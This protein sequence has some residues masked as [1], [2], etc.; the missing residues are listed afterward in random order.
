MKNETQNSQWTVLAGLRFLLATLVVMTHSEVVAPGSIVDK[1]VGHTGYPAVFGFLMIS[2]YSIASSITSRPHSYLIRR[3]KRIYPTFLFALAFSCLVLVDGPLHLPLGQIIVAPSWHVLVGNLLMLQGILVPVIPSNGPLWSLSIE[4]W[5]YILAI[6]LIRFN[7]RVSVV[8][9]IASFCSMLVYSKHFGYVTASEYPLGLSVFLIAWA[10]LSGFVY[11][12]EPTKL[13]FMLMLAMPMLMF[14]LYLPL[15][16]GQMVIAGSACMILFAKSI[17]IRSE[18]LKK[19]LNFLGNASYPL[20]LVHDPMLWFIAAKT[21]IRH[22]SLMVAIIIA[23]VLIGYY[24]TTR[25]MNFFT[26]RLRASPSIAQ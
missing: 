10:W 2:G 25:G 20:Y 16:F 8:V 13:N 6:L 9:M 24:V 26:T 11:N 14:E 23:L 22:G 3:V 7:N 17:T 4:W 18:S 1:M 5:C 15:Q 21:P 19:L 12:R